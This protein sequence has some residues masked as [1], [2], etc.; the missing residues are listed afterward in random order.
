V[1]VIRLEGVALADERGSGLDHVSLAVSAGEIVVLAGGR[2]AGASSLLAIAAGVLGPDAGIVAVG[3]RE[4][5]ALQSSSL[6]YVRRNIGYLPPEPPL[7]REE[8]VLENVRVALAMRGWRLGQATAAAQKTLALLGI[9]AVADRPVATLS[10]PERR[11]TAI[12]RTLVGPPPLLV[13]DEPSAALDTD[14]RARLVTALCWAAA[15]GAA[16]LCGTSDEG[17]ALALGELGA[18]TVTLAQGRVVGPIISVLD[19]SGGRA[20]RATRDWTETRSAPRR[21]RAEGSGRS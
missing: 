15:G 16:V 13:L 7:M 3:D 11:L 9:E 6:P 5:G 19:G 14:D 18:R 21:L 2:G 8:T 17:L 1:L 10:T 4:L 20:A 12:A